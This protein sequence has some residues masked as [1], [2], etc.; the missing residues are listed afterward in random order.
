MV[1]LVKVT[2]K[3]AR[4][5]AQMVAMFALLPL[6]STT[7]RLQEVVGQTDGVTLPGRRT[8]KNS[9]H[10]PSTRTHLRMETTDVHPQV[11]NMYH[12][13]P[14]RYRP[15]DN[16]PLANITTLRKLWQIGSTK[17]TLH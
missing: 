10:I 1:P 16:I 4:H 12:S 5:M 14:L 8:R 2:P 15:R 9:N 11:S 3:L 17:A 6:T 13:L 7:D